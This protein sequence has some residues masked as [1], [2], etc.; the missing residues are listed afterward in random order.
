MF[1]SNQLILCEKYKQPHM[2]DAAWLAVSLQTGMEH[3]KTQNVPIA[4][5]CMIF[6][7]KLANISLQASF[8]CVRHVQHC[9]HSAQISLRQEVV[10]LLH[11]LMCDCVLRPVFLISK[12]IRLHY[13]T[14]RVFLLYTK[15]MTDRLNVSEEVPFSIVLVPIQ[16]L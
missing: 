1:L 16:F 7:S 10:T 6:I 9:P 15:D 3:K 11:L 5:Y 12:V 2:R 8:P 4:A 13:K 14:L